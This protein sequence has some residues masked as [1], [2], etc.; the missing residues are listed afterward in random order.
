MRS[1]ICDRC[2]KQEVNGAASGHVRIRTNEN[3]L[4][5]EFCSECTCSLIKQLKSD[6]KKVYDKI[7]GR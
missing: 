1:F 4:E 6:S 3:D 2:G 7:L 5:Y